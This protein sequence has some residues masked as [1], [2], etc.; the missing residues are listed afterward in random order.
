VTVDDDPIED[1]IPLGGRQLLVL[2]PR[3]PES[4]LSEVD[5]LQDEFLPYWAELW[6]SALAL[7]RAVGSRALHGARVVELGCGLGLPSIAAALAGGRVLATDWAADAIAYVDRNAE[8]ND[9]TIETA[10]ESWTDPQVVKARAPWDLVIGS[11]LLYERRNVQPLLDLLPVLVGERGE[12]WIA[13]PGRDPCAEFLEAAAERFT[14][15]STPDPAGP[16]VQVHR[17]RPR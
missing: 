6:P 3:E 8:H 12:A 5:F 1:V 7:A 14:I 4:L 2:R 15:A 17:L 13:D 16:R 9:V 11:D 10:V